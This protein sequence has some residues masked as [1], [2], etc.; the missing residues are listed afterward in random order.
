MKLYNSKFKIT[1][2][3]DGGDALKSGEIHSPDP[4]K[5]YYNCIV[6]VFRVLN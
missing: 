3:Y 5:S 4:A 6:N 2:I 1:E